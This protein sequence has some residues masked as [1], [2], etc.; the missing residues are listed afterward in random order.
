[1]SEP[2]VPLVSVLVPCY[3]YASF[4]GE[5]LT[6]VLQQDY[7]NFELIV[8]DDGSTDD[9][10]SVI[11]RTIEASK[12]SS[13]A[14]RVLFLKQENQGVSAAL[15]TALELAEG[16]FVATFDADDV[17]P[18][19]RL[20]V[21][22]AY[23]SEH[24]EVGC[25]GGVAMRIDEKGALLPKK[26]KKR[27]IRRYDFDRALAEALVVGGNIAVYRRDAMMTVGG[28]D[29]AIK[30]QDFQMTLK[31]AHEGY[32]VDIL[33]EIVTLYRKHPDSLSKQYKSEYLYG[34]Q[35][36]RPYIGHAAYSSCKSKL[37]S[38]ALRLAVLDDKKYAWGLIVKVP[39][40]NWDRQLLKRL[41]Y[42]LFK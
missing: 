8:V 26:D 24:P 21:Q 42:L 25:L 38:K 11:E 35:V 5:A 2:L 1:M 10:V 33:P 13:R 14:R 16:E 23:L 7:P 37:V 20:A 40:V 28:Y 34:L 9:S 22:A 15:N 41:R 32:F 39:F 12:P 36:I 6:S 17:M 27:E 30:V 18:Q 3:N 31:I 4:V 19:G 29:P